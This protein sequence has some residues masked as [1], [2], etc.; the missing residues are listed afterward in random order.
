MGSLR[1]V[2]YVMSNHGLAVS[3]L[4]QSALKRL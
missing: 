1:A 3:R 4:S 2:A